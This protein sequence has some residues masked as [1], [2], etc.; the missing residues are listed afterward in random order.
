MFITREELSEWTRMRFLISGVVLAFPV[1]TLV[2]SDGNRCRLVGHFELELK[3]A[4]PPLVQDSCTVLVCIS[5][6]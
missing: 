4:D 6:G 2:S 5:I 1:I 3:E